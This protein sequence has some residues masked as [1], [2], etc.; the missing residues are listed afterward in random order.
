MVQDPVFMSRVEAVLREHG[1]VMERIKIPAADLESFGWD[2]GEKAAISP[3]QAAAAIG[4][5]AAALI[6]CCCV[7]V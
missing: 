4:V 3:Q 6:A 1:S 5:A 2:L 7:P